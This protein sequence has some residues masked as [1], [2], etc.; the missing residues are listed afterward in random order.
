MPIAAGAVPAPT[1]LTQ[2]EVKVFESEWL[3]ID[4]SYALFRLAYSTKI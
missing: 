2:S 3:S 1:G 4:I